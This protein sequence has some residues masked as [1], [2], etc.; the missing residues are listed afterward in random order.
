MLEFYQNKGLHK[1]AISIAQYFFF[2]ICS[3]IFSIL[4]FCKR[5]LQSN[6]NF[7][8]RKQIIK[9]I[10]E[11]CMNQ[12][13]SQFLCPAK[14]TKN[15]MTGLTSRPKQRANFGTRFNLQILIKMRCAL[16]ITL[17]KTIERFIINIHEAVNNRN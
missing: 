4:G 5:F 14:K 9:C 2:S 12:S 8:Q 3:G 13:R 11:L 6:L 16:M 1:P 15:K 17:L 7:K 10:A